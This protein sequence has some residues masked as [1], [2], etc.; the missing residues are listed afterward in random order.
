MLAVFGSLP[1][2]KCCLPLNLNIEDM[3]LS[4]LDCFGLLYTVLIIGIGI[5]F[6]CL[7]NPTLDTFFKLQQHVYASKLF[8]SKLL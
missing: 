3:C 5:A 6:Y 7:N 1:T 4:H 2:H 8:K